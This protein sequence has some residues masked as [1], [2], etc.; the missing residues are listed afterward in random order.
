MKTIN[1]DFSDL[2]QYIY[3]FKTSKSNS[4]LRSIRDELNKFFKDSTCKDIIYTDNTDKLFFGMCVMPV[5]DGDAAVKILGSNEKVRV[6]TYYVEFDSR[7]FGSQL[8]LSAKELTAILLHEIG[9]LVNDSTPVEEVRKAVD[10]YLDT[11]GSHISITDSVQYREILAFAI[12]DSLRKLTSLFEA[13]DE[14][15]LA[16][17]FVVRCG[18]GPEL[19][20]AFTKITKN[21][22]SLN[23]EVGNKLI[24]L[25]WTLRLYKDVKAR[26]IAALHALNRGKQTTASALQTREINWVITKLREIDDDAMIVESAIDNL[27]KKVDGAYREFRV[28][29]I[30]SLEEDIFD[31]A[32]RVK[33]VDDS[34][35][36]LLILRQI[37]IKIAMLDDYVRTENIDYHSKKRVFDLL[38]KYYS[39]RED[40]SKKQTYNDK[41]YS[42]W[43]QTPVVQSRYTM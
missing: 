23:K 4:A 12:K 35:E 30:R 43:V 36:A 19:Q 15:I 5:L 11:T 42:L 20:S 1:Y 38:D 31:L 8:N 39:L 25:Q 13:K 16:D 41:Y 22:L 32:M 28:K 29:G 2:E 6:N 17:E 3:N 10:V 9:H 33:N 7:I 26:R 37:N 40:L 18:Y 34:D 14:E 21:A 27:V 24:V